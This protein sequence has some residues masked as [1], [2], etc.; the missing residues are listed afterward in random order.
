MSCRVSPESADTDEG[1]SCR[2]SV[3]FSAVTMISGSS[4][5]AGLF[6][7]ARGAFGAAQTP[8]IVKQMVLTTTFTRMRTPPFPMRIVVSGPPDEATAPCSHCIGYCT[9]Y[10]QVRFF[11]VCFNVGL[12]WETR[13]QAIGSSV[14]KRYFLPGFAFKAVVIGGGFATG[15]ELAEHFLPRGPWGGLLGEFLAMA[16]WGLI[17]AVTFVFAR[18]THSHDYGTFFRNLLGPGWFLFDIIYACALL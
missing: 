7:W 11:G 12:F 2:R 9:Q 3:R 4:S 10:P 17:C 16:L 13:L 5:A 6:C 15:R 8:A 18:S 14:F 1:T